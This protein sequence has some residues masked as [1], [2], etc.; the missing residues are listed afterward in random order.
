MDNNSTTTNL[1]LTDVPKA[2]LEMI[3]LQAD[4]RGWSRVKMIRHILA[5]AAAKERKAVTG[6][7]AAADKQPADAAPQVA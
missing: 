7:Y 4:R 3:E 2:D 6:K 5:V 1:N